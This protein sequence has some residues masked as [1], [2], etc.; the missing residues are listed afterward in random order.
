[1]IVEA[2]AADRS[3]FGKVD[4]GGD[5]VEAL[6]ND[7]SSAYGSLGLGDK[8]VVGFLNASGTRRTRVGSQSVSVA[9]GCELVRIDGVIDVFCRVAEH[10]AEVAHGGDREGRGHDLGDGNVRGREKRRL[11]RWSAARGAA[12]VNVV[13][14]ARRH[15][16]RA[17]G[18]VLDRARAEDRPRGYIEREAAAD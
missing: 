12:Q 1:M 13:R 2:G 4:R 6:R 3:V 9:A 18:V 16:E 11:D 14:R 17:A 5:E 10:R 7:E 8:S 15:G